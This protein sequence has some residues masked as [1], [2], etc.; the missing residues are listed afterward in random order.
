MLTMMM[1]VVER[2]YLGREDGQAQRAGIG[3]ECAICKEL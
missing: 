3:R 2:V 1:A